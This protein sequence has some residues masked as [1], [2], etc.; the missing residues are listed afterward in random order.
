MGQRLER[1]RR[2]R[3]AAGFLASIIGLS[4]AGPAAAAVPDAT[5]EPSPPVALETPP[6]TG[7]IALTF[8]DGPVEGTYRILDILDAHGVKATFFVSAWRLPANAAIAR[9][10]VLRGH[11]LQSHGFMHNRWPNMSSAAVRRDIERANRLIHEA[12]GV[13]PSCVRPPFGATS[14]RTTAVAESLGMRV[15]I[16]DENSADYAH[17]SSAALLRL[18]PGWEPDSVVLAHDTNHYIWTP[19]LDQIIEL[20]QARG[21]EFVTPCGYRLD[22]PRRQDPF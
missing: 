17:Q 15:V 7:W 8:D 2:R 21:L 1:P 18:A 12:A 16:W 14:A 20:L 22:P 4:A 5:G 13:V 11:S 3:A 10:I 19:V 9:E 6:P